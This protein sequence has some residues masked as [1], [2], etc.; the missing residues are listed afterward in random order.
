M[1]A[2]RALIRWPGHPPPT[3]LQ[4]SLRRTSGT[5]TLH[6]SALPGRSLAVPSPPD[7]RPYSQDLVRHDWPSLLTRLLP[8]LGWRFRRRRQEDLLQ[9]TA[10]CTKPTMAHRSTGAH[11]SLVPGGNDRAAAASR[12]VRCEFLSLQG[13]A[14]PLFFQQQ[15]L[16]HGNRAGRR[17]RVSLACDSGVRLVKRASPGYSRA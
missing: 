3:L 6:F 5:L 12:S 9:R 16:T 7:R 15:P 10:H 2:V 8:P 17:L 1:G 11:T 14:W 4:P 13:D